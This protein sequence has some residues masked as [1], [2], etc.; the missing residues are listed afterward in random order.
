LFQQQQQLN[1][2]SNGEQPGQ[3]PEFQEGGLQTLNTFGNSKVNTYGFSNDEYLLEGN[4]SPEMPDST[5]LASMPTRSTEGMEQYSSTGFLPKLGGISAEGTLGTAATIAPAALNIG[6]GLFGEAEQM[7]P[8]DYYNPYGSSAINRM[9]NRSFDVDPMLE[10][11]RAAERR[12]RYNL[13]NTARTRGEL[14]SG[15]APLSAARS[16]ADMEAYSR[17]EQAENQYAGQTAQ[18]EANIG[19]QRA[20]TRMRIDDMNARA[21][22]NKRNMLGTGLSQ[23]SQY[24]QLRKQRQGLQEADQARVQMLKEMYPQFW[25][26]L[27]PDSYNQN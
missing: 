15:Y 22:A 1:G 6:R 25:E 4:Y 17:R 27:I 26:Q 9:R 24:A 12:G 2:N 10:A 16:R 21:R 18:M 13:R 7:D 19:Q 14:L 20:S 3:Q 5:S 11:N 23:A 8:R